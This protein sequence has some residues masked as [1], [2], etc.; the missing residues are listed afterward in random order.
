MLTRGHA[1][2]LAAL[3]GAVAFGLLAQP[4][5]AMTSFE[6][7]CESRAFVENFPGR[8]FVP[9]PSGYAFHTVGHCKGTLDGAPFDGPV[10]MDL[11]ADMK[12]LMSCEFGYSTDGGPIYYTFLTGGSNAGIP[13]TAH[14]PSAQSSSTPS[15]SRARAR[16]HARPKKAHRRKHRR[17]KSAHQTGAAP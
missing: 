7:S 14:S 5:A 17:K 16:A 11:Y 2:L 8:T 6:G 4:S 9:V 15:L 1:L 3:L 10:K 12:T 13:A